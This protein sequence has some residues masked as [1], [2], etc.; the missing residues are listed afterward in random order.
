MAPPYTGTKWGDSSALGTSAGVVTWSFD[1]T[2]ASF[3]NYDSPI[4]GGA[5]L[6][7]LR[8]AFDV[9]EHVANIDF[10]EAVGGASA[11]I[12]VGYDEFDGRG[13][14]IGEATW[15]TVSGVTLESEIA[16]D[17]G[18][19]FSTS[20][21]TGISIFAVAV[22]EIGHAIGFEHTDDLSSIM[23]P[24]LSAQEE[25]SSEDIAGIQAIY[26]S[27]SVGASVIT[28]T[29]SVDFLVGSVGADTIS[30]GEGADTIKGL[31]GADVVSGN[32]G[33]DELWGGAA[34]DVIYG[35]Q[36]ADVV[37]GNFNDDELFGN[38]ANDKIY[39]G[40]GGDVIYGGQ[41]RDTIFGNNGSDTLLGNLG[42]DQLSGGGGSDLFIFA[43]NG[44]FDVVSDFS[45]AEGDRLE[46]G[47]RDYIVTTASDGSAALVVNDGSVI[48]LEGVGQ[49]E[50]SSGYIA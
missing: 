37:Y 33:A 16:L 6:A 46:L 2:G 18:D 22:H 11:D 32:Q 28:G 17:S 36:D 47:G 14:T 31:D 40:Q 30:A 21:T 8:A 38:L 26:G 5:Y 49:D 9:W 25:P 4:A 35:G 27:S 48:V 20:D 42:D 41:G 50:L 19:S 24:Y 13:G 23:Y 43:A 45:R 44:G 34:N 1:V 12:Q 7:A 15:T 3:Y 10:Q 29:G 39:G